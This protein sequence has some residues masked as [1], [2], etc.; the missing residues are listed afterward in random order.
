M[1]GDSKEVARAH[2]ADAGV[3]ELPDDWDVVTLG[4]LFTEDRGIA[5]GVMYPGEHDPDGVP[6]ARD[7]PFPRN[8]GQRLRIT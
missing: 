8:R 5:V 3:E 2:L 4:D 7:R 1:A 6:Q